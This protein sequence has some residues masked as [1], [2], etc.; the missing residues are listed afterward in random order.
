MLKMK[1][2]GV[3]SKMLGASLAILIGF[4]NWGVASAE[5]HHVADCSVCHDMHGGTS[6]LAMIR[7]VITTPNSGDKN[8]IFLY[9]TGT[10]SFA[11]GDTV[12]DG[13]CEVCHTSTR[14]HRNNSSDDTAHFDGDDCASCHLHSNEF[15]VTGA[16]SHD[17][18]LS[19]DKGPLIDCNDCHYTGSY[20]L[21]VDGLPLATT[22]ACDVCHSPGGTFPGQSR[23]DDPAVGAKYN[24]VDGVYE[25][26][27]KTI[28]SGKEKWCATCHD[29]EPALSNP[30]V[31]TEAI[32]VDNPE[33]V[34]VGNWP[35]YSGNPD[36]YGADLRYNAAGS[37]DDT[38]TWRPDIP[39]AG[40]YA[41]YAW[42]TVHSNRATDA[43]YTI[44]YNGGPPEE[45]RVNQEENGGQ[46]NY[47]GTWNFAKG[48][49]GYVVLSD[50][51][52][53]YVIADAIK[54]ELQP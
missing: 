50:N 35:L 41:V 53:E 51:A 46:W 39:E 18:H 17:T 28:R 12:Y 31:T 10:N 30:S 22:T 26:D 44:H 21:F 27:G 3:N 37:G 47:L 24:W 11:D 15:S 19:S 38:A 42:W 16:Q 45:V 52:N 48:T 8:V 49:S 6:N 33:A 29:N 40:D 43:P 25:A 20:Q 32:V 14:H 36:K 7:D 9:R 5:Y 13:V 23:L 4:I 34:F 1:A 54:W 2:K